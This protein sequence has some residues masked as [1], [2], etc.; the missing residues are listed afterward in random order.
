[1]EEKA[2]QKKPAVLSSQLESLIDD[3]PNNQLTINELIERCGEEGLL[4]LSALLT[5]VFLIPVSIPGL[6]TVF[7]A[8]ILLVGASRLLGKSLWLPT[9]IREH[10]VTMEKLRPALGRGLVWVHRLEKVSRPRRLSSLTHG[11]AIEI[12]N[13]LAF[14]FATLLLMMPFGFIPFSNTLPGLALLFYSIGLAQRDGV[15]ILLG[16]LANLATLIYFGFLIGGGGYALKQLL[17]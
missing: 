9:R 15:A 2:P 13:N 11:R 7:G 16:H 12:V 4:L 6:S 1:M 8:V 3:L 14:I 10:P 5:L 17:T